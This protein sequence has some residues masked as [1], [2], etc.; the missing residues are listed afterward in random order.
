[1]LHLYVLLFIGNYSI[2]FN[3]GEGVVQGKITC[4]YDVYKHLRALCAVSLSG[5]NGSVTGLVLSL[6]HI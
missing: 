3:N 6:I 1:M 4:V 2:A 5:Q